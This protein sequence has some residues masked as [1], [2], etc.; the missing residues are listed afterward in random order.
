[1][2]AYT[3]VRVGSFCAEEVCSSRIFLNCYPLSLRYRKSVYMTMH[4]RVGAYFY[5]SVV[6]SNML[7]MRPCETG[8]TPGTLTLGYEMI[9]GKI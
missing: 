5:F 4:M 1:M 7:D 6:S 3:S 2:P 9:Y 8:S